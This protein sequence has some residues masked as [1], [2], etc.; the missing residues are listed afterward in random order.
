[1]N[2]YTNTQSNFIVTRDGELDQDYYNKL[3]REATY[4]AYRSRLTGLIS[5]M[6]GK[7]VYMVLFTIAV[8]SDAGNDNHE[9][10]DFLR[11]VWAS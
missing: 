7:V 2:K 10:R 6:A 5:Y 11:S 8:F 3:K 4:K 1:M 9:G